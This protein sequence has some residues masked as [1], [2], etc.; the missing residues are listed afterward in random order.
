MARFFGQF[1]FRDHPLPFSLL[2]LVGIWAHFAMSAGVH[3]VR[4][5]AR[6]LG[7]GS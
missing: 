4:L 2:V 3:S 7:L 6:R 5:A 1:Q